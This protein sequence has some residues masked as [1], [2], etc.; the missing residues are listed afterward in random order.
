MISTALV[1]LSLSRF[2]SHTNTE[3]DIEP[4]PVILFGANGIGKTNILEAV[5]L[6]T[7]GRGLRRKRLSDATQ[8]G[9]SQ[10]WA[11]HAKLSR[12]DGIFSIGTGLETLSNG[13]R[14]LVRVD[15]SHASAGALA[16]LMRQVW[17]TPAQDRIF[18]GARGLRLKFFDRLVFSLFPEHAKAVSSYEKAMRQ[19]QK[20]LDDGGAEPAWLDGLEQQMAQ[21]ALVLMQNRNQ[22]M[23]RLIQ[24]IESSPASAFPKAD[25]ELVG[26]N[27]LAVLT[28]KNPIDENALRTSFGKARHNDTRAGRCLTGP[29]RADLR[30]SWAVKQMPASEC[31]TG[32]QKALLVGLTLAHAKAVSA[33]QQA[34]API[35]LLDEACAHL[36]ERR[37][38]ALID[39]LCQ[40]KGQAWLSGTDRSLFE[41]FGNRAQFFE[42]KETGATPEQAS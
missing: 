38:A 27:E 36:D 39:E 21:F 13:H 12:Q 1:H 16:Q 23:Q 11:V 30:V 33:H 37:R 8:H 41:H 10:P 3:L 17:L 24:E 4:K 19:R 15:G 34:C 22:T 18:S 9:S 6:L 25:L 26:E 29:H 40:L 5:S 2:R 7:P 32:E 20:L 31:S 28:A 14:R 35:I 42:I